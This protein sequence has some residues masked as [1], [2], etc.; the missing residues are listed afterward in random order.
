MTTIKTIYDLIIIG[1]G[2]IG[3]EAALYAAESG[4]DF[5]VLEKDRAGSNVAQW[6]FVTMFS[7]R[8]MNISPLGRKYIENSHLPEYPSGLEMKEG[9]YDAIAN[10]PRIKN[11]I[12]GGLRV[13]GVSRDG[14][15]KGELLGDARRAELP[16]LVRALDCNNQE[17]FYRARAVID[18]SGVYDNNNY[19]GAGGLSAKGERR[20]ASR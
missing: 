14:A 19:L 20:P 12:E 13:T 16:F 6:G 8:Q 15:L 5:L 2:P 7:P 1:A 4:L 9:Y 3:L 17:R 18:A 11:R 10:L